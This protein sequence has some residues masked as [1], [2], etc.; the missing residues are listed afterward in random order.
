MTPKK[1]S[2]VDQKCGDDISD[3]EA[4][5]FKAHP[6]F[7]WFCKM[8]KP[9]V[10][11]ILTNFEKFKKM[12][13]EI[14]KIQDQTDKRMKDL[15]KRLDKYEKNNAAIKVD[16]KIKEKV[17][18]IEQAN[19]EKILMEKKQNN[20]VYFNIPECDSSDPKERI[21]EDRRVFI[22]INGFTEE[23]FDGGP[24]LDMFRVG[25]KSEE[26]KHRPLIVKFENS[27]KK[28]EYLKKNTELKNADGTKIYVNPDLTPKQRAERKQLVLDMNARRDNGE[29]DLVIRNNAIVNKKNFPKGQAQ[30]TVSYPSL[31]RKK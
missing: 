28:N 11:Q 1:C 15:E 4:A 22:E 16:E 2:D 8:C 17:V 9:D 29:E 31:F 18:N 7:E 24:I 23:T 12:S 30:R 21:E 13:I 19:T 20:L 14:K 10:R 27:E 25:K 3:D 5:F 6:K 26:G